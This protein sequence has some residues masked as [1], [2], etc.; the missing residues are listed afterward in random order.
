LAEG[1]LVGIFPEGALTKDGEIAAFKSGVE[2]ILERAAARGQVVPVVPMALRGMWSSMW[3]RRDSRLGRMRVP[4]RFRAHVGVV[5]DAP[6]ADAGVRAEQLDGGGRALRGGAAEGVGG[7][8]AGGRG[9]GAPA[10][11]GEGAKSGRLFW[12]APPPAGEGRGGGPRFSS[13]SR[14]SRT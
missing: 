9:P 11:G 5:A 13:P 6:V 10:R 3:S 4:R 12:L 1:E 8:P 2:K 7:L 14:Q